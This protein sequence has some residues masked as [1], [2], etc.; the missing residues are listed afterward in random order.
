MRLTLPTLS[1]S[2]PFL[3]F[4]IPVSWLTFMLV[5]FDTGQQTGSKPRRSC[6]PFIFTLIT[7]DAKP[8]SK[9]F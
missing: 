8:S 4:R 7:F 3:R 9:K 2:P 1:A 6:C 5:D